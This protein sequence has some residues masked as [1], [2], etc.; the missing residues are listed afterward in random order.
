MAYNRIY[1]FSAGPS[2][3]PEEV[4]LKAQAELLNCE[5]SGESVTEMSHRSKVFEAIIADAEAGMREVMAIPDNY[6]VMFLQGGASLQFAMVPMN[7]MT[8]NNKADYIL[9]GQ[10]STKAYEESLKYGTINVAGSTKSENFTRI[11][12]QEELKLD[13]EADYVHICYNNTIFGTTWDYIPDTG[14]VPLVADISSYIMSAPLDISKFGL[15]YAGAQK[16]L[17]PAGVT[18]VIIREDLLNR[19]PMPFTP[20]MCNYAT[21]AKNGS[22]YNTPPCFSIYICKL[23]IDWI[24]NLGGL[25]AM[26]ALNVK[27]AKLLYD[28]LDKSTFFKGTAVKENRSNMNVT[29]RTANEELDKQFVKFTAANGMDNL[30]GHRSVGGMRAS[31]YNAMPYEGVAKLVELMK[32]FEAQNA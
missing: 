23:V 28:Y 4:L 32:Q 25:N 11:P 19:K 2:M 24:K 26:N 17:A 31:I 6:K 10:F 16:N 30:N 3:L 5:G 29:F 8:I 21:M 14:N 27:K 1:N 13:P 15:V 9:T 20:I 22:M 12:R 7:L 18:V